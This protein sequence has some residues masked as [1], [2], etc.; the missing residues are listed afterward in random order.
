MELSY[1]KYI[2]TCAE[3]HRCNQCPDHRTIFIKSALD[4]EAPEG[5]REKAFTGVGM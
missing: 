4:P 5:M 2:P 3:R 1:L